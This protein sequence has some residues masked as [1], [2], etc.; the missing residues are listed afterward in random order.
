[1]M[2]F[3][4]FNDALFDVLPEMAK[5]CM[6]LHNMLYSQVC[7]T[8]SATPKACDKPDGPVLAPSQP[9]SVVKGAELEGLTI[10]KVTQSVF[11]QVFEVG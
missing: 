11:L 9:A 3:L 2:L 8:A 5:C 7:K 6:R 4:A 10:L 1:M